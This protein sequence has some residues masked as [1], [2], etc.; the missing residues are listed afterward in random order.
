M[1]LMFPPAPEVAVSTRDLVAGGRLLQRELITHEGIGSAGAERGLRTRLLAREVWE[2]WD[3]DMVL[4]PL[5]FYVGPRDTQRV[6][7]AYPMP[8][9][10]ADATSGDWVEAGYV[11]RD[12]T[13][14]RPWSNYEYTIDLYAQVQPLYSEWQL[15][16]LPLVIDGDYMSVPVTILAGDDAALLEWASGMRREL[17]KSHAS[18]RQMMHENW[19]PTVKILLRL[20]A[21]YWPYVSGTSKILYG[22][23]PEPGD[24]PT[25]DAVEL[26]YQAATAQDALAELGVSTDDV[27]ALYD[28]LA[29]RID[30]G[31]DPVKH[32]RSL[33]R[34]LPRRRAERA[35]GQSR[36]ALDLYDACEVVRRFYGELTGVLL[37]DADQGYVRDRSIEPRPLRKDRDALVHALRAQGLTPHKLH[38]VVEGETEMRLVEGLFEA[39]A[40][41]TLGAAGIAMTDLEGD[42]LEE[43][44]RFIEGFGLYARDVALLLDDENDAR[45]VV[46]HLISAGVVQADHAE[47]ASPS[48]EQANFT[49]D[50]LV[51]MANQ[52]GAPHGVTL[53]FTGADLEQKLAER[54]ALPGVRPLGMASMLVKM[55]RNPELGPVLQ[56][57]KP[58]LAKPMIDLL[59]AEISAAPGKHEEVAKRR[60][61]VAWILRFPLQASRTP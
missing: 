31:T 46:D 8:L 52:L 26:E 13:D 45:R 48:L 5:A 4:S 25:L 33:T 22:K 59:L 49:P 18:G 9:A 11:F 54:N 36:R 19:L 6:E 20:Q 10:Q 56:I 60:P 61:I 21:R 30:S 7:G 3:R 23:N 15:L 39:F 40:G 27:L 12:E 44:R 41:T 37:P 35:R 29:W 2:S 58:D 53:G 42:K 17:A 55:A 32:L 51:S 24:R 1:A 43:S 28:W 16:A 50:E 14:F 47:L 38:I 34:L 57:S